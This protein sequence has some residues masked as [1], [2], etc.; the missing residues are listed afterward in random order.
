MYIFEWY[1]TGYSG[2]AKNLAVSD[3][4]TLFSVLITFDKSKNCKAWRIQNYKPSDFGWAGEKSWDKYLENWE[5][6]YD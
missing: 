1:D 2:G 6:I 3:A 4:N 5:S